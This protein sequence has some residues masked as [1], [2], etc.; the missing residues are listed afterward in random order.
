MSL[1]WTALRCLPDTAALSAFHCSQYLLIP[2][3]HLC[4]VLLY[5]LSLACFGLLFHYSETFLSRPAYL[6]LF[7]AAM[8]KNTHKKSSLHILINERCM[9]LYTC[10]IC[11][12][13]YIYRMFVCVCMWLYAYMTVD[14]DSHKCVAHEHPLP[15]L[16]LSFPHPRSWM[17]EKE[18]LASYI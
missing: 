11:T 14:L 16:I 12:S 18:A 9:Y 10:S 7:Q 4:S 6:K 5:R 15:L 13:I 2:S 8:H 1:K 3:Q 17:R